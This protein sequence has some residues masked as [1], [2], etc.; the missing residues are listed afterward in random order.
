MFIQSLI[1]P[2]RPMLCPA[3]IHENLPEISQLL[4][5]ELLHSDTSRVSDSSNPELRNAGGTSILT[6]PRSI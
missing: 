4:R 6:W 5:A 2:Q 1:L 3:L